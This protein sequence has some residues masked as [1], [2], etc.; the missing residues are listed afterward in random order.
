MYSQRDA[1]A[2]MGGCISVDILHTFASLY[3][4]DREDDNIDQ[5]SL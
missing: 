4:L 1:S 5:R 2:W 3:G